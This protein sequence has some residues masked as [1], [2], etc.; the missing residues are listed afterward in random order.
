LQNYVPNV[1]NYFIKKK[2]QKQKQK[3]QKENLPTIVEGVP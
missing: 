2:K 3:S 1:P